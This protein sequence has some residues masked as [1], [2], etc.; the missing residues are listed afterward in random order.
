M[1]VNAVTKDGIAIKV[2]DV[3]YQYRLAT[4][5]DPLQGPLRKMTNPYPFLREAVISAV[6]NCTMTSAGLQT[7]DQSVQML[8]DTTISDYVQT[9]RLDELLLSS[10]GDDTRSAILSNFFSEKGRAKFKEKGAELSNIDI[11]VFVT[12]QKGVVEQQ[13]MNWKDRWDAVGRIGQA[14]VEAKRLEL[15]EIARAEAVAQMLLSISQAYQEVGLPGEVHKGI[16]SLNLLGLAR[17]LQTLHDQAAGVKDRPAEGELP[18]GGKRRTG[19]LSAHSKPL[20]EK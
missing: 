4:G 10:V 5:I 1:D 14:E 3:R 16:Q 18:P 11:G 12:P 7:W 2:Q 13:I 15:E 6:Y 20:R 8:V 19:R 9:R 17:L